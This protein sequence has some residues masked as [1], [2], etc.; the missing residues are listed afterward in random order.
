MSRTREVAVKLVQK[1][2]TEHPGACRPC[3][4]V[5]MVITDRVAGS[6][7]MCSHCVGVWK[8][9][10]DTDVELDC[11]PEEL[12]EDGPNSWYSTVSGGF[13]CGWDLYH[14]TSMWNAP[15]R[16]IPTQ[17][18]L[19]SVE[20]TK[21]WDEAQ[22]ENWPY[23]PRLLPIVLGEDVDPEGPREALEETLAS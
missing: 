21:D 23:D 14:A 10:L 5:G 9:P 1:L 4:G 16:D 19:W 11:R 13:V 17:I 2:L 6:W 3:G 7:E 22:K 15:R 8:D 18:L 12:D 20:N